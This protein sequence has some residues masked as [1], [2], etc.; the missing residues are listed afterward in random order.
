MLGTYLEADILTTAT[1]N[2]LR[3]RLILGFS[4]PSTSIVVGIIG[5]EVEASAARA[6]TYVFSTRGI[7]SNCHLLN[8]DMLKLVFKILS[9]IRGS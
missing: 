5:S 9:Q 8:C 7:L 4:I 2:V 3:E 6:S 1:D